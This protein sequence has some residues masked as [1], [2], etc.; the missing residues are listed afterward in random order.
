MELQKTTGSIATRVNGS[1]AVCAFAAGARQ[2]S[3]VASI[4]LFLQHRCNAMR[5][6]AKTRQSRARARLTTAV[7]G[8][9]Y[10]GRNATGSGSCQ[11]RPFYALLRAQNVWGCKPPL[12]VCSTSF[13]TGLVFLPGETANGL[14]IRY[15][16]LSVQPPATIARANNTADPT[17]HMCMPLPVTARS[18]A[19]VMISP[20]LQRNGHRAATWG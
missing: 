9:Q 6:A 19:S 15:A 18:C 7:L 20:R 2:T 16:S 8:N 12:G 13:C 5:F 11:P 1:L 3:P 4:D 10:H 14:G 17:W